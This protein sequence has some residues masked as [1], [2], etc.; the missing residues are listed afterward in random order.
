L[1]KRLKTLEMRLQELRAG[2]NSDLL[3][4]ML[5]QE[6]DAEARFQ[7]LVPVNAP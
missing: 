5:A 1:S 6:Q 4:A 7:Q 3:E 2:F